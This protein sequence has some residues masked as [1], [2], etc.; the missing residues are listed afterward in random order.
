MKRNHTVSLTDDITKEFKK[1]CID[2]D[3]SF[4]KGLEIAMEKQLDNMS[5]LD[6]ANEYIDSLKNYIDRA[7][8]SYIYND[9][10]YTLDEKGYHQPVAERKAHLKDY[11]VWVDDSGNTIDEFG[12]II[13]EDD[14]NPNEMIEKDTI[15]H[16]LENN[17]VLS[18]NMLGDCGEMKADEK[19]IKRRKLK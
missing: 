19:E 12:N 14:F 7:K 18:Y 13:I 3:L 17:L 8:S 6:I 16:L 15:A 5:E 2:N 4:S 11:N 10:Y 9:T 1:Y